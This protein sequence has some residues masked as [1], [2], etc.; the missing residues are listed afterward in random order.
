VH[1]KRILW[2]NI[3]C[4]PF[5]YLGQPRLSTKQPRSPVVPDRQTVSQIGVSA[6]GGPLVHRASTKSN[7]GLSITYLFDM[8]EGSAHPSYKSTYTI[9]IAL[10]TNDR[11]NIAFLVAV[12]DRSL[13]LT[14]APTDAA[15]SVNVLCTLTTHTGVL[16]SEH[17]ISAA[18]NTSTNTGRARR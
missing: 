3:P 17:I 13:L 12:N 8:I 16:L 6:Y 15:A 10:E 18:H 5:A 7:N 11:V 14:L 2:A 4:L 1:T 9:D